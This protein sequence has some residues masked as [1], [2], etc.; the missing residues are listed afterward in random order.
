MAI[1][2]RGKLVAPQE[3]RPSL[4]IREND[5]QIE[6]TPEKPPKKRVKPPKKGKFVHPDNMFDEPLPGDSDDDPDA[7]EDVSKEE[8]NVTWSVMLGDV[9]L[10]T[11]SDAVI[12]GQFSYRD[13]NN[14]AIK[15][16]SRATAKSKKD[17]EW[18]GTSGV[19][20]GRGVT[21]A[22]ERPFK[23]NDEEGWKKVETAVEKSMR[24]GKREIFFKL[25]FRYK[26]VVLD[27]TTDSEDERPRKKKKERV[28]IHPF[29]ALKL[30]NSYHQT[31]RGHQSTNHPGQH[32][33][34]TIDGLA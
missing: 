17:F 21:K 33:C 26:K 24:N 12:L 27:D 13:L 23:V 6:K 19:L 15:E 1:P 34:S 30:V 9:V 28:C 14:K 29:S 16:V 11:D 4:R 5:A 8:F 3:R 20:G 22:Q 18:V 2:G 10:D 32:I 31:T 7:L 25:T